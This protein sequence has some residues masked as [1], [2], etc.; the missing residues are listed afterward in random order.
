[1]KLFVHENAS[2]NIVCEVVAILSS[3]D[4]LTNKPWLVQLMTWCQTGDIIYTNDC[5]VYWCMNA[6]FCL[7]E[8]NTL[9]RTTLFATTPFL[10]WFT[11]KN[12][13]YGQATECLLWIFDRKIIV[14][15]EIW[16][17]N[18][19]GLV[20]W[21]YCSLALSQQYAAYNSWDGPADGDGVVPE[22]DGGAWLLQQVHTTIQHEVLVL[23]Y[24][25]RRLINSLLAKSFSRNIDMCNGPC[26]DRTR[27]ARSR[28]QR[29]NHSA[30]KVPERPSRLR[31]AGSLHYSPL[32]E[33]RAPWLGLLSTKAGSFHSQANPGYRCHQCNGP[34]WDRTRVARSRVQRLNHSA[35]KVPERPSRLCLAGSLHMYMYWQFLLFLH[36]DWH[37]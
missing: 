20:Q 9:T 35:I 16:L 24:T 33:I 32:F 34:C 17:N 26:W 25:Q 2:E 8:L 28:V 23:K 22:C 31:L 30:I 14:L 4:E 21:S 36:I 1:M 6:S 5:L 18:I 19:D 10:C 15:Q 29:L 3:G 13:Y 37:R 27:V 7:D 11:D 12:C